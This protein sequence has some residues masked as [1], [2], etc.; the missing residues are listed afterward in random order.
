MNLDQRADFYPLVSIVI[1]VYNGANYLIESIE[2]ALKQTYKNTEV[3]V[4]NDGSTDDGATEAIALSYGDQI[5]YFSKSN[6]GCGSALNFGIRQMKGEYFSWLSHDD[7]YLPNKIQRQIDRLSSLE[8]KNSL[9]YGGYQL[10][11]SAGFRTTNISLNDRFTENQLNTPL[12]AVLEGMAYGCTFLIPVKYFYEIGF[13]DETLPTTQDYALWYE[14]F[15]RIPLC[16]DFE[17]NTQYRLH[18]AQDTKNHPGHIEECN[19]LWISFINKTTTEEKCRTYGS[20][21]GFHLKLANFLAETPYH[22]ARDFAETERIN[23]LKR[24]KISVVI[25]FYN[26]IELLLAALNSVECQTHSNYEIILADD[27]STDPLNDLHA[28]ISQRNNVHYFKQDNKGPSCA[29]NLGTSKASGKYIAFLDA[30]DIFYP[31]KLE[32]Q[33]EFMEKN[34]ISFS[35][36]NYMKLNFAGR[37]L[38]DETI[39]ED[40]LGFYYPKIIES[41][42]IATTTVMALRELLSSNPFNTNLRSG[43]DICLWITLARL[44]K[45]GYLGK[46]LSGVRISSDSHAY[47]PKKLAIGCLNIALFL[48]KDPHHSAYSE[49]IASLINDAS[50]ELLKES[51]ASSLFPKTAKNKKRKNIFNLSYSK[52]KGD[53][54][55][56][57][58]LDLLWEYIKHLKNLATETIN[59]RIEKTQWYMQSEHIS[60][61]DLEGYFVRSVKHFFPKKFWEKLPL[62]IEN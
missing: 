17:I 49:K 51:N 34:Q 62:F 37:N 44:V 55:A 8:N 60:F 43:E 1:P 6:G 32:T 20:E 30:D 41:C 12:F 19:A 42:A 22:R 39:K 36:T 7:R 53:S 9:V 18:D 38:D 59:R 25:P 14:F 10:I 23:F 56:L 15:R 54:A 46:Q 35:H 4:V 21:Y 50:N 28:Y 16:V 57:G 24:I 3:I 33:L 5:R 13:F 48:L 11:N 40:F 45:F 58:P 29:R 52:N 2:S 47:D 27:G 31:S 61:A 26:N